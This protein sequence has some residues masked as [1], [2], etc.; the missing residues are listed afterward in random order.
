MGFETEALAP[1]PPCFPQKDDAALA[2][3]RAMTMQLYALVQDITGTYADPNKHSIGA[4]VN[5]IQLL[6][7]DIE[8]TSGQVRERYADALAQEEESANEKRVTSAPL[9]PLDDLD[10]HPF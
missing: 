9:L 2:E 8:W 5:M 4:T 7:H 6:A 3:I 10:D 1:A